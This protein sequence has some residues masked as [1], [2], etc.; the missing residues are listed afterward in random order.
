MNALD[1]GKH[2]NDVIVVHRLLGFAIEVVLP[3]QQLDSQFLAERAQQRHLVKTI[4]LHCRVD[5]R[6]I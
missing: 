1:D 5:A 4:T 2:V 6:T 3:Q